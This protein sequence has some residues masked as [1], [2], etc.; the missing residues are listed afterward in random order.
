[1]PFLIIA[2]VAFFH[3][4]EEAIARNTRESLQGGPTVGSTLTVQRLVFRNA[5]AH[6]I[7]CVVVLLDLRLRALLQPHRDASPATQ[8]IVMD[9]FLLLLVFLAGARG[10]N[11]YR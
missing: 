11:L 5:D 6:A 7:K 9:T 2:A 4:A 3:R 10:S 1:M 8:L